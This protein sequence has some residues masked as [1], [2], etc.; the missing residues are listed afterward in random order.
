MHAKLAACQIMHV[1]LIDHCGVIHWRAV[2]SG[3][4]YLIYVILVVNM[5]IKREI[6]L[7]SKVL[8]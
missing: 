5:G 2:N 6:C 8:H 1:L 4:K 3:M 7:G